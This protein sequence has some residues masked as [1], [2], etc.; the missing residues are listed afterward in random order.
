MTLYAINP[1]KYGSVAC[2]PGTTSSDGHRAGTDVD[3]DQRAGD[4]AGSSLAGQ[5]HK[6]ADQLLGV[7][8]AAHRRVLQDGLDPLRREDAP[9]LLSGEEARRATWP[10]V[11]CLS[12]HVGDPAGVDY[13]T[14]RPRLQ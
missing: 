12:G 5:P 7:A 4:K 10:L 3:T 9:V 1:G 6:R 2:T 8:E 13:L 14:Q 11:C